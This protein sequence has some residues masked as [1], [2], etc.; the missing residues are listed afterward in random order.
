MLIGILLTGNEVNPLQLEQTDTIHYDVVDSEGK[1]WQIND[2]GFIEDDEVDDNVDTEPY[3]DAYHKYAEEFQD[4]SIKSE[5]ILSE[6]SSQYTLYPIKYR[7]IYDNYKCQQ[8]QNWVVEE[9]DL[10][11]DIIHWDTLLNHNDR[12]FIMHVL[13]F[14]A[15][16]DGIVNANIKENL[17]DVVKIKEGECAYGKQF[18]MENVHGEMYSLLIDTF[19]KEGILKKKLINAIRTMPAVKKKATWC[20]KW[21]DSDKTYAHKLIAFS[22]VEAVFF[23]G[24]FASIFWL[25]TRPG[26]IMPGLR[27]SN[28]FIARD[29]G[30]HVELACKLYQLLTNR[31]KEDVVHEMMREAVLIE[32]EFINAS[33]PCRL[34]GMNADLMSQYIKYVVDRLLIQLGYNKM[35]NVENPFEYMKKIDTFSK[36]NFFE[37][38]NDAYTDSKIDNPRVFKILDEGY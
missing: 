35:Y 13:A 19:I 9:I 3:L 14:F 25:K 33:L 6:K 16:A 2:M 31:L 28:K 23:S 5:P 1:D 22:I 34:L 30:L 10:S 21:I 8:K 15:A 26:S 12:K 32:D 17:I 37:T 24:S 38:R 4:T 20:K 7:S 27:K 36:D 29:E 18:D 11:V